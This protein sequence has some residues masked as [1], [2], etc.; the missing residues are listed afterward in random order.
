LKINVYFIFLNIGDLTFGITFVIEAERF[1]EGFS[2]LLDQ[3]IEASLQWLHDSSQING[4]NLN[5]KDV[6]VVFIEK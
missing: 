6:K 1:D 4:D 5:M 2:E 3:T